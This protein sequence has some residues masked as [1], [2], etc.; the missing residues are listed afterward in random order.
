MVYLFKRLIK[1]PGCAHWL[2]CNVSPRTHSAIRTDIKKKIP[3][4]LSN[5]AASS[6]FLFALIYTISYMD[7]HRAT[8]Q[9]RVQSP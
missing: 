9:Q 6:F 3:Q 7:N 5:G 2:R 4:E 1:N 8:E